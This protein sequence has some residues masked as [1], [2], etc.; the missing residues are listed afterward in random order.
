MTG[1]ELSGYGRDLPGRPS[2]AQLIEAVCRAAPGLRVRLG[3]L[4]PRTVTEDFCR[5]LAELPNLCPHFHLSLQSGCDATLARMGRKYTGADYEET[6]ARLNQ[7]FDRPAVTTDLIVGFPGETQEDFEETMSL[8]EQVR[9]DALFTFIFSPRR[10]TPAEKL[11]DPMPKEQKSANFQRLLQRQ[12]EISGEKHRQYIGKTCRCLVDGQG[13]DGLL[14]ARTAGGRLVHLAADPGC[15]GT[16]RQVRITEA[17]TWA[18]F[19]EL[20]E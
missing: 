7:W 5:A 4:E 11:P 9:Y 10:G 17:S 12:N 18:L 6:V 8:I 16:W 2:L 15:I 20:A 14:T 13:S 19:G 1:I 3:S